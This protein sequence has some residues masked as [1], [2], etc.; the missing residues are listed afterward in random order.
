MGGS[1]L[2]PRL[3]LQAGLPEFFEPLGTYTSQMS[4]LL[5]PMATVS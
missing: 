4:I 5:D 3:G 1:Y 2:M